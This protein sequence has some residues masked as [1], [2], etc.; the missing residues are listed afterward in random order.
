MEKIIIVGGGTAGWM[1]AATLVKCFPSKKICLI[2]SPNIATIGASTGL[3]LVTNA[4]I[5]SPTVT[6][7]AVTWVNGD[8]AIITLVP[9][10]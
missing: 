10:R 7:S 1:T 4:G 3:G 2:E 8:V 9:Y 5:Q 6:G